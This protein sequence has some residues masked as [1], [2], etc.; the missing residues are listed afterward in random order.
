MAEYR[1][2]LADP[3]AHLFGLT[4]TLPRPA[5]TQ[6]FSLPAW[7]P[8]SYMVR[9]FARHLSQLRARQGARE[10]AVEQVAKSR[11]VVR[12]QG[13]LP[14]ELSWQVY[15]FDASVRGAFLD[16]ARGFVNGPAVFLCA[17]GREDEPHTL[18]LGGL[19][20]G[21]QV[22]TTLPARGARRFRAEGWRELIDHPIALGRFWRGGFTA[23]GV[24]HE[25]VVEGAWP[26]FD[27][28]RLV[29]DVQRLCETQ[30]RF[31]HGRGR[32]P[33]DRYTF[34]LHAADEGYG[35]LEHR[36]GSAL[37]CARRDLPRRGAAERSDGYASLLALFSHE[38]F[39]A[40]N[41][42]RMRPAEWVAPD[43]AA[44]VPTGLLWFYEGFTAYY[45]ELMLLRA[46]LVDRPRYLRAL[47]RSVN[48]V[49]GAPGRFVQSVAEAGF[50]A[51][52]KYY[53]RDENSV[54][55]TV[56]YYDKGALVALLADLH[57]RRAGRS[58]DEVMR[59]LWRQ[60]QRG[61][62]GEAEIAAALG[63]PLA[64]RLHGWV[65]GRAELPL[66]EALGAAGVRW[67]DD[68]VPGLAAR[69]GLKVSEG[70]VTGLQVR[71][72][73]RGGVAEAAG[74][75]PG[76]EMLAA[77]GWRLR[78][79]DDALQWLTEG[80]RFELLLVRDQRVLGL[81]LV[82]PPPRRGP[83]TLVPDESAAADALVL[84]RAWLG[85]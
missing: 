57:L 29:A 76:D 1:L 82:L 30:I 47:A 51:W 79:L 39:H 45:D 66:A 75:A 7:A 53:R 26:G 12:T 24:A 9:D 31:W 73:H 10:L 13:D 63:E 4:L 46:G 78:R 65:H 38:Y 52:T 80:E 40:W 25:V 28:E 85:G 60:A 16:T 59:A 36:H 44:E 11:W 37:Q 54:N 19:P 50:D 67:R 21:W 35:G 41:V 2:A 84:R 74:L 20:R 33:F 69:L 72:V 15:A 56:S 5:A 64:A 22:A 48:A 18:A 70:P 3:R 27:G 49:L 83:V 61:P 6:A 81:P 32:P 71:E 77:A 68:P 42:C 55:A 43:L 58:L 34:L 62:V 23:G 17:E 8:G 14:L